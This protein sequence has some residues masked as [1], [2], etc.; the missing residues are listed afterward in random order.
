MHDLFKSD[1]YSLGLVILEILLVKN[2]FSTA[3]SISDILTS[4]EKS[5]EYAATNN[6]N[7][8]LLGGDKGSIIF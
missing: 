4:P 1:I 2:K 6:I 8:Y 3:K 7:I 5:K